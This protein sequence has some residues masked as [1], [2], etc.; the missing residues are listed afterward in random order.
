MALQ[1]NV[2]YTDMQCTSHS[3]KLLLRWI[4]C[5]FSRFWKDTARASRVLKYDELHNNTIVKHL[6][7]S[8]SRFMRS[9][10]LEIYKVST[11]QIATKLLQDL[12]KS[13]K[14]EW[15]DWGHDLSLVELE[16]IN[17]MGSRMLKLFERGGT[18]A[19]R[20]IDRDDYPGSWRVSQLWIEVYAYSDRVNGYYEGKRPTNVTGHGENRTLAAIKLWC[21]F[22]VCVLYMAMSSIKR[23][24]SA[25]LCL[26]HAGCG[27]RVVVAG[28]SSDKQMELVCACHLLLHRL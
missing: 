10:W 23:R 5:K 18:K 20:V 15:C 22:I 4:M 24:N 7:L 21:T 28:E 1:I 13:N 25:T 27:L 11:G 8:F 26:P 16:I 9:I 14:Q 6:I 2:N 17:D 19:A 12:G 3:S